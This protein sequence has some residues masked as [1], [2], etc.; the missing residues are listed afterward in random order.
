MVHF[1]TIIAYR[2]NEKKQTQTTAVKSLAKKEIN[3]GKRE[4]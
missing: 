2:I 4:V 3:H 1:H